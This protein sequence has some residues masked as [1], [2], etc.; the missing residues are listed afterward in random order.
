MLVHD[1][2]EEQPWESKWKEREREREKRKE[3]KK[4]QD[5]EDRVR[6]EEHLGSDTMKFDESPW[7][8]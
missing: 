8:E 4:R 6:R 2:P 7:G 1:E 3:N 5:Q